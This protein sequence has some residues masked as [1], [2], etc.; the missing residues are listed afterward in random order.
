MYMFPQF[1]STLY[2][3][4]Y[5]LLYKVLHNIILYVTIVLL[6]SDASIHSLQLV[7]LPQASGTTERA[8][9]ANKLLSVC[10]VL[11]DDPVAVVNE[12]TSLML[13]AAVL[14]VELHS[15]ES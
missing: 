11:K 7:S 1:I 3:T 2:C 6:T 12:L 15:R 10:K 5:F 13:A 4:T 8:G 9:D 14:V